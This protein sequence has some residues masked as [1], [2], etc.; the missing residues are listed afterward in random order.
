MAETKH[1]LGPWHAEKW[2]CH[3]ATSVLVDDATIVI[4]KRIIAECETEGDARLVAASPD[5]FDAAVTAERVLAR[6][7]WREDNTFDP[8]AVARAKLRAA[9][10]KATE[11]RYV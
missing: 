4:G 3:A 1:T 10:A 7:G 9:L 6:M 11:A 5:R 2:S 8:E